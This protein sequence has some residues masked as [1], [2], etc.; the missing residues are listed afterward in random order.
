MTLIG[1]IIWLIFG[2][3]LTA[4]GYI[5]G[6]LSLCLT[7]IGIPFGWQS[8]KLGFAVLTPF[9]RE[10]VESPDANSP[11]LMIFNVIWLLLFGW[12]L[13]LNHLF[14]ALILAVTIVGIPFAKQH[15]KLIILSL[16]PFGRTLR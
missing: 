12:P 7:I 1:N 9:G 16:L 8:I 4:L 10:V 2:G 14:W 5:L 3:F 13:V 15:M 11:L 6:G